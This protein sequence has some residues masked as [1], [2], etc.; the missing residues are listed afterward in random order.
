VIIKRDFI[1]PE[2]DGRCFVL[3]NVCCDLKNGG[4]ISSIGIM[5]V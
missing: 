5:F 4:D 3:A 1:Y 2:S